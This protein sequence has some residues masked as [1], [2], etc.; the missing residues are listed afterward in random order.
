MAVAI[1]D[2]LADKD[3]EEM[4]CRS[5]RNADSAEINHYWCQINVDGDD[6]LLQN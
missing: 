2:I 6:T 5:L 3:G 4:V 1:S